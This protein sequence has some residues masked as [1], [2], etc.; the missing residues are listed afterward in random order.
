M[1]L[2]GLIGSFL[3]LIWSLLMAHQMFLFGR[4]VDHRVGK[5][6]TKPSRWCGVCK[7]A[8]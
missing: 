4:L 3:F 8:R 1:S 2:P 5:H 6:T 7:G